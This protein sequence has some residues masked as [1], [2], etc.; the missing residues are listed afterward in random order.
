MKYYDW[1]GYVTKLC[2][3]TNDFSHIDDPLYP[4]ETESDFRDKVQEFYSELELPE[5]FKLENRAEHMLNEFSRRPFTEVKKYFEI[6]PIIKKKSDKVLVESSGYTIEP[7]QKFIYNETNCLLSNIRYSVFRFMFFI[8][9]DMRIR[10]SEVR[11]CI[12]NIISRNQIYPFNFT[13]H[14]SDNHYEYY[15]FKARIFK[16]R[17]QKIPIIRKLTGIQK[18]GY[19]I[20]GMEV[21]YKMHLN[22]RDGDCNILSIC[23]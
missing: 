20:I 9:F 14:F 4:Y 10:H 16:Y 18:P 19:N 13:T 23:R 17:Y 12:F 7:N 2:A 22:K 3:E 1:T 8:D 21:E 11:K 5:W 15:S 6:V